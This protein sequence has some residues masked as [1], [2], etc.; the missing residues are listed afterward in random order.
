ML[1]S[2]RGRRGDWAGGW[3]AVD[4]VVL[5]ASLHALE[6]SGADHAAGMSGPAIPNESR[7]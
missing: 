5:N 7:S 4:T 2:V 1:E 3:S 6:R